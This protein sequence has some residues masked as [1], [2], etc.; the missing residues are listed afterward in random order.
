MKWFK[1]KPRP[2]TTRAESLAAIPVKNPEVAV[3]STDE[4]DLLLAYNVTIRPLL[5]GL[6]KRLG[7][8]GSQIQNK[9]LQLDELGSVTWN[10]IDGKRS[11]RQIAG[12]F[13]RQYQLMPQEAEVSVTAFIRELGRRGLIALK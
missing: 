3:S 1:K 7:G 9:K 2:V 4:G 8:P 5:A 6:I 12:A 11:V 13:A 10:L